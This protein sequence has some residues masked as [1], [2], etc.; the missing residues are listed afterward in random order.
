MRI[1]FELV[2]TV[3]AVIDEG[4]FEAAAASLH[5]TPSAVSQRIRRAEDQL[6]RLLLVRT[7]P[8][9]PTEAG[10]ALV[11]LARQ[12]ALLEHETLLAL[13]ADAGVG[14]SPARIAIAVNA[15]SLGT[16]FLA[17]LARVSREHP[18]TFELYRDDQDFT[19][20]LLADGT[21]MA[22]VTSQGSPVAGRTV[23][24][25][26]LMRY[27]AAATPEFKNQW[28]PDGVSAESL[29]RAPVVDYDRHDDLQ[30]R[31]LRA[32]HADPLAP[33]RTFVPATND[34]ATAVRLGIGWGMLPP[35][36]S[37]E[38]FSTGELV[39][40]GGPAITV[41][42]YWQ[43]WNLRSPLLDAVAAEVVTEARAMLDPVR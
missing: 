22:A 5:L 27:A 9:Q 35:F 13:G 31:W 4:T 36:Q 42:L 7:K 11:R 1:P 21:V 25:L 20:D 24:P 16:W 38:A 17:P 40:L 18:V 23:T 34:F 26:G 10:A 14:G 3:A 41:P 8:V 28:F 29:A 33:P 15:D 39:P 30:S 19:A 43:R 32:K 12:T 6:G 37:R 2:E